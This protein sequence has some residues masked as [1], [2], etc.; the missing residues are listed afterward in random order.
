MQVADHQQLHPAEWQ[1]AG[2]IAA[3]YGVHAIEKVGAHHADFIDDQKIKAPDNVLFL[4]P[5]PVLLAKCF[6]AGD[7]R[8]QRQLKKGVQGDAAG[9]DGG[10]AG[11]GRYH[12]PFAGLFLEGM[13]KSGLAGAGL[14]GQKNIAVGMPDKF[15]CQMK[16]GILN[17]H[18]AVPRGVSAI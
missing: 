2:A 6:P 18:W 12:Q 13:Q 14:P 17:A 5:E 1:I 8:S 4:P 16:F 11:R 10:D 7:E 9:I 3:K 15:F